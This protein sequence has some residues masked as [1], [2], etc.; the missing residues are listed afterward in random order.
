M[1]IHY[2]VHKFVENTLTRA[3]ECAKPERMATRNRKGSLFGAGLI[4][5][6][7]PSDNGPPVHQVHMA[8]VPPTLDSAASVCSDSR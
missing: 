3:Q 6:D 4:N 5:N 7:G 2:F 8:V 1:R